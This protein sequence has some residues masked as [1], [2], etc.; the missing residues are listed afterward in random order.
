VSR[1]TKS[2][3]YTSFFP[4][5]F[6]QDGYV[7]GEEEGTSGHAL[8]RVGECIAGTTDPRTRS[9]TTENMCKLQ[10]QNRMAAQSP[11][12]P[13]SFLHAWIG[14]A[15]RWTRRRRAQTAQRAPQ[16]PTHLLHLSFPFLVHHLLDIRPSLPIVILYLS[17]KLLRL[18]SL[19]F[20]E[21]RRRLVCVM[22]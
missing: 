8:R 9:R 3:I 1:A 19:R 11:P 7:H 21:C 4:A 10:Q 12:S 14:V 16:A 20:Q 17:V 15:R 5:L 6:E 13:L 2:P 18:F 22:A